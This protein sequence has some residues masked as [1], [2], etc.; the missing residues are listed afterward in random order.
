L[1]WTGG[2]DISQLHG[3]E[4]DEHRL[5]SLS[6]E[7]AEAKGL[8]G[9]LLAHPSERRVLTVENDRRFHTWSLC[10]L[11]VDRALAARP[12]GTEPG[13]ELGRLALRVADRLD[14]ETCGLQRIADLKARAW[15][16]IA[17]DRRVRFDLRGAREAMAK[18]FA[19]LR[20]GTGDP[21]ERAML[22]ELKASLL[23]ALRRLDQAMKL[24]QRAFSIFREHGDDHR[25]GRVLIN[26]N[27]LHHVAG[28]P[29]KGIPL[30]YRAIEMIDSNTE[31]IL[32]LAA[33][34]NLIDALAELGRFREAES[35]LMRAAAI[36]QRSH[37]ATI[38]FRRRWV[39]GK[40]ALGL[41]RPVEAEAHLLA[42]RDGFLAVGVPYDAA[43]VSLQLALL[44][45]EQKRIPELESL[46]REV[47]CIF[48]ARGIEREALAA[49]VC[50]SHA[51]SARAS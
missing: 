1:A 12:G 15:A 7:R 36:Y 9:Q 23:R 19:H 3:S 44:Y 30:L 47:L 25:A 43:L 46:A 26:I 14:V 27:N 24:L 31:P 28:T 18:A 49:L 48:A 22:L 38:E 50:L 35:L 2:R 6:L 5:F 45:V 8:L 11:L 51:T 32:V 13:E 34:H 37:D 40:I 4:V 39:E 17:N 42:A 21:V 41:G 20:Q 33:W 29:E 16:S 10:E